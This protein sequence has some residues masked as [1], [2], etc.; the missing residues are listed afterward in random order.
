M[1]QITARISGI[2][3]ELDSL[4]AEFNTDESTA[5]LNNNSTN[6]ARKIEKLCTYLLL[7]NTIIPNITKR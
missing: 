4:D 1:L 7:S 3:E 2:H 5:W 6:S